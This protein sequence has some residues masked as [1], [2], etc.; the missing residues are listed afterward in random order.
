MVN[1]F[2][3]PPRT[4]ALESQGYK[5]FEIT[6]TQFILVPGCISIESV[7]L[8]TKPLP[9]YEDH[10]VPIDTTERHYDT[11]R[12]PNYQ[13]FEGPNGMELHRGLNSNDGRWQIGSVV[14]IRGEWDEDAVAEA[15]NEGALETVPKRGPGRPRTTL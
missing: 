2:L 6:D 5:R 12:V 11:L 8:N 9:P 14:M 15:A 4:V 7:L 10:V 13:L 1:P 3:N